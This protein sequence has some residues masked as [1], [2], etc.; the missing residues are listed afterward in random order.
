M[1]Y[2]GIIKS[3]IIYLVGF[4]VSLVFVLSFW[5]IIMCYMEKIITILRIVMWYI[6]MFLP[7]AFFC[8][9]LVAFMYLFE[10]VKGLIMGLVLKNN[11][12]E[13]GE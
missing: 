10:Y 13:N 9:K 7:Y 3:I 6:D 5:N 2:A 8:L 11:A 1:D 12:K 4:F